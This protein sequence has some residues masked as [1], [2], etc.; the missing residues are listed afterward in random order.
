MGQQIQASGIPQF[1]EATKVSWLEISTS[2]AWG[3][4]Y[5]GVP[6]VLVK[7]MAI[8]DAAE[9]KIARRVASIWVVISLSAAVFIGLNGRVLFPTGLLTE[10]A[11]ENIFIIS[12]Q[13]MMQ[14]FIAGIVMAGILAATIS[15]ADSYLLI[16]ASSVSK[17]LYQGLFKQDAK[18]KD[19]LK[20]TRI[21]LLL[22]TTIGILIA[23]DE[24][25]V[26]FKIV[27]FAWA[28]FGATFG[29]LVLFLYFQAKLPKRV[30]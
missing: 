24:N 9:I 20:I 14:P 17:N 11:S 10:S 26:I 22:I 6:Q 4:G 18:D 16:G 27:S 29:P 3:L 25:S 2:L 1:A 28:G 23:L 19:V 7:F 21:T 30:E 13:N 15:S 5:F 8:R 12:A